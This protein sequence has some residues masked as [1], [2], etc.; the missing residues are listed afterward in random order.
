LTRSFSTFITLALLLSAS[1]RADEANTDDAFEPVA[2]VYR[3][4]VQGRAFSVVTQTAPDALTVFIPQPFKPRTV[5]LSQVEAASGARYEESGIMAWT[6]ADS[7]V[8][9]F[10]GVRVTNCRLDRQASVWEAAKLDG[11]DFRAVGNKPG[12]VLE[13]SERKKIS[14]RY[15]NGQLVVEATATR[16]STNQGARQT[17]FEAKSD[18][19]DLRVTLNGDVCL[20]SISGEAFETTVLVEVGD[21]SL[22]GCG[23]ALH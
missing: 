6:Q 18:S 10:D 15:N 21:T 20:D 12:W 8:F 16:M 14:L 7:A 11:V 4:T 5:F 17:V 23:R 9:G 1:G 2:A 3:C 19:G 13:I 22:P